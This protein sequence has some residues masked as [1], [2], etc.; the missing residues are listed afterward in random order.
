MSPDAIGREVRMRRVRASK[1]SVQRGRRR[2][3][4][5]ED[6]VLGMYVA[7]PDGIWTAIGT[8]TEERVAKRRRVP[9]PKTVG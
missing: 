5:I 7:E 6:L 9:A 1:P 2:P 3:L 8:V 4:R